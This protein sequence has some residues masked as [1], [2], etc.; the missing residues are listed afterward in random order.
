MERMNK[1]NALEAKLELLNEINSLIEKIDEQIYEL[2][3]NTPTYYH[4]Y[5]K[6]GELDHVIDIKQM[7]RLRLKERFNRVFESNILI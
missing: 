1:I 7:A 5:A 3:V 4:L 2:K 6:S